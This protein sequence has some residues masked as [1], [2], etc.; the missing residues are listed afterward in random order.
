MR[1][2]QQHPVGLKIEPFAENTDGPRAGLMPLLGVG[3]QVVDQALVRLKSKL[4]L[5]LVHDQALEAAEMPFLE[6][7][8]ELQRLADV[9]S[10]DL[11]GLPR[12]DQ[13]ARDD[14]V[15]GTVRKDFRSVARLRESKLVERNVGV[16]LKAA[17]DIPGRLAM[18]EK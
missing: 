4:C 2:E 5:H 8:V 11:G 7:V 17:F 14:E 10:H 6:F 16:P 15:D 9:F 18:T 3:R 12:A 1:H 13:R